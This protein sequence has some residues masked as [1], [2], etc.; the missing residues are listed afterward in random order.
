MSIL[1]D[2]FESAKEK[3]WKFLETVWDF[4][5]RVFGKE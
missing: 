3:V 1:K 4:L 5:K 2:F